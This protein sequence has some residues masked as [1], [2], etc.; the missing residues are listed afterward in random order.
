MYDP[1]MAS[2]RVGLL[3]VTW[4]TRASGA[5]TVDRGAGAAASSSV[6]AGAG[7]V[8]ATEASEKERGRPGRLVRSDVALRARRSRTGSRL[9]TTLGLEGAGADGGDIGVAGGAG[10]GRLEGADMGLDSAAPVAG[11]RDVCVL[12][13]SL[14]VRTGSA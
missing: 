3:T 8:Y 14:A 6:G 4:S 13:A 11:G 7:V 5:G 12:A 9:T 2:T 10:A 1:K